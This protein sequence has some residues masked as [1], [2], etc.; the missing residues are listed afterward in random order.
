[1]LHH[2]VSLHQLVPDHHIGG[3]VHS[4]FPSRNRTDARR[5]QLSQR[6]DE[7]RQRFLP[8]E[9]SENG[10]S[11]RQP[12]A[13]LPVLRLLQPPVPPP[14]E[15]HDSEQNGYVPEENECE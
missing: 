10:G 2:I 3:N 13:L 14:R 15:G 12:V 11:Q 9:I 1:M 8:S 6:P 4:A 5:E 7:A